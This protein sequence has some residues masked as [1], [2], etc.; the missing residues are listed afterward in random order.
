[1]ANA[2]DGDAVVGHA[3]PA[4][5]VARSAVPSEDGREGAHAE[6]GG[7]SP[8]VSLQEKLTVAG[9]HRKRE[10]SARHCCGRSG[11]G[12]E[13]SENETDGLGGGGGSVGRCRCRRG[14]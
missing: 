3:A 8:P 7:V 2:D 13:E 4:E 12:E 1:M 5:K 6:R 9:F 10:R 14:K 11:E